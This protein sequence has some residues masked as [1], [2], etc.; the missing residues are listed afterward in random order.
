[1]KKNMKKHVV[2]VKL[3]LLLP[4]HSQVHLPLWA[5]LD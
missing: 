5:P 4:H 2:E 1:M 3:L